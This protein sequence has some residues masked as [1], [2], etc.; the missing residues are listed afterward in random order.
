M[1]EAYFPQEIEKKW[2]KIWEDTGA[3]KTPDESDKPKYY[4]LS[5]FPYPSGKLHMGHVRNYTITDVIARFKK[6]QGFNVLHPIGWDSFGLPAEN[7]AMKHNA[8]PAKWT[9]ENIAYMTKQLKMLGLS[10]DWDREVTTCKEEYYK[11]TQWLFLQ[12]YKK[13]LAYKKEAAV[14]WCDK[15]ATV[16]ANEQVIDGKCWRCDSVVEKKYLSQWFLKITD[17]AEVLLEDLDKLPGWGDNVKTMQ[18][19]WIGKSQGAIFNFEV[20]DAPS[21]EK[22][23]VPVYTTRP[24]TVHGITYLVVA[25]EYK[26]IEKLTTSENKK[27]VEDYRAN[28]RKMTEIERLSNERVK[29]GVP[30]GTHCR[31]PFNG[32]IFPL[33]TADYAL[34]EYG[35]GAVM[36]VPTHD[37]RD[38]DFAKKYNL[39]MKVVIQ[40]PENPSD[41]K[42]EAYTDEGVLINSNEF[43]GMKNTEAKKAITQK[44]VDGGFGEF[45]TQYRLRDW[46]V[47][48]Q[49][50]WGAPIPIVYCPKCGIQP[51]PE[52][53]L[54]VKLPTDVDFS[55]VGKSP[56]LTSPTFQDTTCPVCGGPAKRETDTMDTF[57]CSSWYYLRYSDAR[58]DKECFNK[59][60]VNK[61]LPVDQYVG[62]IEHAILHLLYSRF[63][64]KALRDLGLLDFDEPFKNLLTQG[65][66]LKDGSKMSKSKGNTV[67]PDEIFE[68]YGADTARLF[69]LSD[70]PPGR[71]FDWSDAGVEGCY[72]FLNRVWRLMSTNSDKIDLHNSTPNIGKLSKADDDLVR[73]IHMA[74]KSITN[75]ISNDFQFNTV[76]SK[77]RELVNA[78][79]D[80]TSKTSWNDADKVV[81]SFAIKSMLKL[82]SPVA[83]HL[84]EEAWNQLG[85]EGSIHSQPWCEWDE[86]LAKMSS[87]TLVVQVNGKVKDKIEADEA[88]SQDELKELALSSEKVKALTDGKTIVK[89]IV[90]PKKLVNIVVK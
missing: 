75:D 71:D 47:S 77:Y 80:W 48:R 55:V 68:N 65:M 26:D 69:I 64:T 58:N 59:D 33:W 20:V 56:I 17:Y 57:V 9:D 22:M 23:T 10:Y 73:I 46:L 82:M 36:A 76:I 43:N 21:G 13:G 8:D 88:S 89:V 35:T 28:A 31:N 54:P 51:V 7:A 39:P 25:P 16:L 34:V 14:N 27:A 84:T 41:C 81:F 52:D 66:V 79:Y 67:D 45:K 18:A 42:A 49:R 70:S 37:T 86:N 2:Q 40:N 87:I 72:K 60:K 74:I 24:D 30:L 61:W 44:A 1:K 19:N 38:F 11:W 3:F 50:Y 63:F 5:M 53:Q 90:V 4:A 62:G 78:I 32:E 15:C 85:G 6:A 12:L 83:V 29:T